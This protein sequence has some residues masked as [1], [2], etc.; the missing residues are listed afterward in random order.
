M[1]KTSSSKFTL[2]KTFNIIHK[3]GSAPLG[4]QAAT[5]FK[6]VNIQYLYANSIML[7]GRAC[8]RGKKWSSQPLNGLGRGWIS[9]IRYLA[10][11]YCH[12]RSIVAFLWGR[13]VAFSV[14]KLYQV[15]LF[16][17]FQSCKYLSSLSW[18]ALGEKQL[19]LIPIKDAPFSICSLYIIDRDKGLIF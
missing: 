9:D 12:L 6:R 11:F 3:G 10:S 2:T 15:N 16:T 14:W 8:K 19:T 18:T 13:Q 17:H 4:V 5:L 1:L 7:A